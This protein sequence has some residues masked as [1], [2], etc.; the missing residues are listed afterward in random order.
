M[1][2]ALLA[3]VLVVLASA[4][5]ALAAAQAQQGQVVG[6]P[7][8]E[9]SVTDNQVVAGQEVTL[10]VVVSN[11][12]DLD[13]GGPR[14]FE[15]RVKTARNARIDIDEER[16][17]GELA[18]A[19]EVRTGEVLAGTIP[20]GVSGP[21][22]FR[23]EI[24]ES[25]SPGTYEIPV[26]VEYD[27]TGIVEYR[28]PEDADFIDFSRTLR[29]T[30]T[31]EVEDR[32]RFDLGRVQ[33]ASGTV[34]AGDTATVELT[35]RNRGTRPALDAQ[36]VLTTSGS[37]VYFGE[38]DARRQTQTVF[39]GS[40][41][42]G[43]RRTIS[44][45]V[46][47]DGGTPSG[48]YP[49]SAE[50]RYE[51]ENGVSRTADPISLGIPVEPKQTFAVE[52][53]TSQLRIGERGTVRGTVVNTGGTAVADAVVVLQPGPSG[54]QARPAEVPVGRLPPGGTASFE[55]PVTV[56]NGTE[57]GDRQLSFAVNY[58]NPNGD[59]RSSDR[60]D[61]RVTVG[62]EQSFALRDVTA[63]LQ[64]DRRGTVR[65]TVV[66]TG[67]AAV[68]DAV[69]VVE[70]G[71]QSVVPVETTVPLGRLGPGESSSFSVPV[72]VPPDAEPGDRQ[73]SFRVRYRDPSDDPGLSDRLEAS[74]AVAPEQT[75]AV[76]NVSGSLREGQRGT[77]GGEVVNTGDA[78]VTDA[79]V[80]LV[81]PGP[82]IVPRETE[83]P[84]GRLG[85]GESAPFSFAVDVANGSDPGPRQV[86]VEVRYR[87]RNDDVRTGG[88]LDARV[89][90]EPA[91]TV[92][93][94][95]LSADLQVGQEGTVGGTVV[96]TGDT[97]LRNA[98]VLLLSE[99]PTVEAREAEYP[100]GSLE[101]GETASF[102]FPVSVLPG[103]EAGPRRLSFRVRYRDANDDLQVT[104]A[105]DGR[106][107]VAPEQSFSVRNVS[108][109]LR[110][111]ES[112]TVRG[113]VENTG[114][115]P[116]EGTVVTL[117]STPGNIVPRETEYAVG[118]LG[119]GESAAFEFTVD[120][121]G[122]AEPG[123]RLLSFAVRYRGSDDEVRTSDP[124]DG[125]VVV[126]P[127][128]DEFVVSPVEATVTAGSSTTLVVEVTNVLDD[129]ITDVEAKLFTTSPLSSDDDQAFV[130]RLEP[131]ETVELRF[132]VAADPGIIPKVYPVSI[133]FTYE[134]AG[135]DSV[136]SDTYRVPVD[137]VE[138]ERRP[139]PVPGAG[140]LPPGA[141]VALGGL[142]VAVALWV[143]WTMVV[144]RFRG[145]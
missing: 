7:Q 4:A 52:N 73:L 47:A 45:P 129:P 70:S 118:A 65:G 122:T 16:L 97:T 43:E 112:G 138:R 83:F 58:R 15:E 99:S 21:F 130:Q 92:A 69:I 108:G 46:G 17:D 3:V 64:V 87:D 12:G 1:S 114:D 31:I 18:E 9:L 62:P 55:F 135:G 10:G 107:S 79:V 40:L 61:A 67:D 66:N 27:Y 128:R 82:G 71:S 56:T 53:V 96:N 51:N 57:A 98:A 11:S 81:S 89:S 88:V 54:V 131:N 105:V 117:A 86:S 63:S 126:G 44:V 136:L 35:V 132:S 95:G 37:E 85:P 110:V 103:G 6:R 34:L 19:I 38:P 133:D 39:L 102:A 141:A 49:V 127:E 76:A 106:V 28:G 41:D 59:E 25:L 142:V 23:L 140:S 137:V 26:V 14:Q 101:P 60:I 84:V 115:T 68:T 94:E 93:V 111:D 22:E 48:V 72:D 123:P 75:F 8:L 124:L 32:A 24:A 42:A 77:I 33:Q 145:V 36:V 113:V 13:R 144:P 143:L 116:V 78:P 90:V 29:T 74:V 104:D 139:L 80:T 91:P 109:S 50:I 119:P 121:T 30:V 2:R 120:V 125:R 20:E 100:V 5:P 134:D